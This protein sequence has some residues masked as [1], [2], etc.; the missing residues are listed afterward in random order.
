M[1]DDTIYVLH[2]FRH[3]GQRL[4]HSGTTLPDARSQTELVSLKSNFR[5]TE[6]GNRTALDISILIAGCAFT[7]QSSST[8]AL[9][10]FIK[11]GWL[12]TRRA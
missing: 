8:A 5:R 4:A 7:W 11:R 9:H 12:G 3:I 1:H 10:S 6:N 2:Y